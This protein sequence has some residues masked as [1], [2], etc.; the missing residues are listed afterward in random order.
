MT[1]QA[2][3]RQLR[4]MAMRQTVREE[5][6]L[7]QRHAGRGYQGRTGLVEEMCEQFDCNHKHSIKLLGAR[8]G[9]GGNPALRTGSTPLY[10][11]ESKAVL[12]R[13]RMA[14]EQPCGRRLVE[15]FELLLPHYARGRGRLG[16]ETRQRKCCASAPR[17][18]TGCSPCASRAASTAG[19]A[20]PSPAA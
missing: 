11:L 3:H 9:W 17:R 19:G 12:W 8:A 16:N 10:D 13:M 1:H 4:P 18:P 7:R 14:A 15:L 20:A 6:L 2:R 5:M